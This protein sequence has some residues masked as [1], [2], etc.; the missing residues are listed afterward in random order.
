MIHG[1]RLTGIAAFL[2]VLWFALGASVT[3]Q[4]EVARPPE[5]P[6][7][8]RRGMD[9]QPDDRRQPGERRF[10]AE[11][12]GDRMPMMRRD[13]QARGVERI[14]RRVAEG[15]PIEPEQEMWLERYMA[16][17]L[18]RSPSMNAIESAHYAVAEIYL[19]RGDHGKCVARLQEVVDGAGKRQDEPVWVT[20]LN[21]ANVCRKRL[22]DMQRA[23]KEYKLVKG[24]WAA[25]AE[26]QLLGTLEEM[27]KLDEAVKILEGQYK[28]AKEKGEKLALLR[29]IA[30]LYLRNNEEEKAIATYDRIAKEFT[31]K[32]LEEMKQAAVEFVKKT[33]DKI[34][35]LR[36]EGKHEE[37]ERLTI[38][39]RRRLGTLRAQG[40]TDEV[41]VMERAMRQAMEKIERWRNDRRERARRRE[42]DRRREPRDDDR[43]PP[44]DEPDRR[45]PPPPEIHD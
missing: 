34:A 4:P 17:N 40:R 9:R 12:F 11:R 43:P 23:I 24:A 32:D 35:A 31:A 27:G 36:E 6:Q 21:I 16:E 33:A 38:E 26:R 42:L 30:E 13:L 1:S 41:Q 3:A 19:R 29:R 5:R 18:L 37:A 28:T 10:Q 44:R 2:T 14:M 8:D 15:E 39:L 20:H 7:P 22:G 25:F 45:P